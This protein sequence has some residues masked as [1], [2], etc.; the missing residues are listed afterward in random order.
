MVTLMQEMPHWEGGNN[1]NSSI[2]GHLLQMIKRVMGELD[3]ENP[4]FG[5]NRSL[6]SSLDSPNSANCITQRNEKNS[7]IQS[8]K[9]TP[10]DHGSSLIG[11][12]KFQYEDS[13]SVTCT[14]NFLSSL[15][16]LDARVSILLKVLCTHF[17][18][19]ILFSSTSNTKSFFHVQYRVQIVLRQV[20]QVEAHTTSFTN[21]CKL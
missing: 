4:S 2:K 10:G 21:T 14:P 5:S 13:Q 15:S 11:C 8:D 6:F 1:F 17:L 3:N 16:K 20:E 18:K 12:L 7:D 19:M 9:V